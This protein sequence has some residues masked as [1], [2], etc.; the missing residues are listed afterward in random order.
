MYILKDIISLLHFESKK[1]L[2]KES[3][4]WKLVFMMCHWAN[5]FAHANEGI[6]NLLNK[7]NYLVISVQEIPQLRPP[8]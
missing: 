1:F 7:D 6:E 4:I 8:H 5:G 3:H 2:Y